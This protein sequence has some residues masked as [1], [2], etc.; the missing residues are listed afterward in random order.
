VR[1]IL[2]L[3]SILVFSFFSCT[4]FQSDWKDLNADSLYNGQ[5]YALK[6]NYLFTDTSTLWLKHYRSDLHVEYVNKENMFTAALE[7]GVNGNK[8]YVLYKSMNGGRNWSAINRIDCPEYLWWFDVYDAGKCLVLFFS[9]SIYYSFDS[10]A[11]FTLLPVENTAL[12]RVPSSFFDNQS[13]HFFVNRYSLGLVYFVGGQQPISETKDF[14]SEIGLAALHKDTLHVYTNDGHV[15]KSGDWGKR[16]TTDSA[17]PSIK[18]M[19]SSYRDPLIPV[20]ELWRYKNKGPIFLRNESMLFCRDDNVGGRFYFNKIGAEKLCTYFDPELSCNYLSRNSL[21]LEKKKKSRFRDQVITEIY[22]AEVVPTDYF[23][24]A[25][26]YRLWE[27]KDSLYFSLQIKKGKHFDGKLNISLV[28][29]QSFDYRAKVLSKRFTSLTEDSTEWITAFSKDSVGISAGITNYKLELFYRDSGKENHYQLGTFHYNPDQLWQRKGFITTIVFVVLVL[30]FLLTQLSKQSAPLFS[31]WFPVTLWFLT[32]G[33][34]TVTGFLTTS[35][36]NYI[37]TGLLLMYL[38]LS[39]PILLAVGVVRPSFFKSIAGVAP[40]H[41]L[42]PLV[43]VWPYFRK[44]YYGEYINNLAVKLGTEKMGRLLADN[45]RTVIENYTPIPAGFFTNGSGEQLH[46]HPVKELIRYFDPNEEDACRHIL[47]VAPGGQ[48]KSALL[49]EFLGQYIQLFTNDPTL[50]LPVYLNGSGREITDI[51]ELIRNQLGRFLLS[52]ELFTEEMKAGRYF[53]IIDGLSE[54]I[55]KPGALANFVAFQNESGVHTPVIVTTRPNPVIEHEMR[56]SACWVAIQPKKLDDHTVQAF[57]QAYLG[58]GKQLGDH[59][60]RICRS[61]NG[62]YLPILVKLAIIANKEQIE[63]ISALYQK[64]AEILLKTDE[65]P[66]YIEIVDNIASLCA[67]TYGKTGNR[68]IWKTVDNKELI[69]ILANCGL[70]LPGC[71]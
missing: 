1:L 34:T 58:A 4:T 15:F 12:W 35:L 45:S 23:S 22:Q 20:S 51:P 41:L 36:K 29:G 13:K 53:L 6:L 71:M 40:F 49:R 63:D 16:W 57:E 65:R 64:A 26:A 14:N 25:K 42:A 28:G 67:A 31:K 27:E 60:R 59:L 7:E 69:N 43:S 55:V 54:A 18:F 47:I 66:D 61:S 17:G 9:K 19:F 46:I 38:L 2:P 30:I 39:I 24:K 11:T 5:D 37:D 44:R 33:A 48:G 21:L 68:E 8:V 50:P 70:L 3:L 52:N 10:G 32:T 62:E 56:Q